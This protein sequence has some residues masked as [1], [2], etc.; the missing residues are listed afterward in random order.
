MKSGS[1]DWD[2]YYQQS[3]VTS[4]FS[5]P[6]IRRRFIAAFE[7]FSKP[8][9]VI[10]ELGGANSRV[11]DS[12][13]EHM[14]PTEYHVVD[15]NRFGLDLLSRRV[16]RPDVVLHCADVQSLDL[17]VQ[18]DAVFSLGL[19]EH[20]DPSGTRNAI[21][22]HFRLLKAGGIAII[23][24]PTSTWLYRATRGVAELAR[25]WT[26]PDERALQPREV[27]G[28]TQ[29]QG[30]LLYQHLIWPIFLTQTLIVVRKNAT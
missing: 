22:A 16:N 27:L 12:V 29:S 25:K 28:V 30:Q 17:P 9:P 19:I 20:F 10:V 2:R 21:L 3:P 1:T 6:M 7:R 14:R 13:V 11:F 4:R 8:N 5:R 26:F 23:S 18:A 24:F 15:N